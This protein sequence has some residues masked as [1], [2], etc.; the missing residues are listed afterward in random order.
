MYAPSSWSA[1]RATS[2]SDRRVLGVR[3]RARQAVVQ[4]QRLDLGVAGD[5]PGFVAGWRPDAGDRV[6]VL[7]LAQLRREL[8]HVFRRERQGRHGIR[9]GHAR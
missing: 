6:R 5:Q 7:Q 8:Q 9:W 4:E 1:P 2:G 3:V